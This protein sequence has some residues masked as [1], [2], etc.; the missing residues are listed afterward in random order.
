MRVKPCKNRGPRRAANRLAGVSIGKLHPFARERIKH[1]RRG[2]IGV[3]TA[4]HILP[5][6]IN[7]NQN[8]LFH[9][10]VLSKYFSLFYQE[11]WAAAT[12]RTSSLCHAWPKLKQAWR[13]AIICPT[14]RY[15]NM[16]QIHIENMVVTHGLRTPKKPQRAAPTGATLSYYFA[17]FKTEDYW[18][19]SFR[20]A[21]SF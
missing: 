18:R 2:R 19:F 8:R 11:S 15:Y 20:L 1:G 6:R 21:S 13:K 12:K 14:P 7:H 16:L 4:E 10:I 5:L 17:F 3:I 9:R